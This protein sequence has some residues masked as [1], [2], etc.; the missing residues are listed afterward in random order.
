MPSSI[1]KAQ[2]GAEDYLALYRTVFLYEL[3]AIISS[4][5]YKSRYANFNRDDK[6]KIKENNKGIAEIAAN[7]FIKNNGANLDDINIV[8][9][10]VVKSIQFALK[11]S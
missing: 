10:L 9:K 7:Y 5:D 6:K 8:D 1:N 2:L 4:N 11:K 3:Q